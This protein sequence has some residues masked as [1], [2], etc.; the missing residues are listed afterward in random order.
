MWDK[1]NNK[2]KRHELFMKHHK[3]YNTYSLV[4]ATSWAC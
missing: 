2:I 4:L 1:T 3:Q